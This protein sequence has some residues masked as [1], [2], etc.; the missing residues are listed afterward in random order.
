MLLHKHYEFA[1][2]IV[3]NMDTVKQLE[4]HSTSNK[5]TFAYYFTE[6][7]KTVTMNPLWCMPGWLKTKADHADELPFVFGVGTIVKELGNKKDSVWKGIYA[8]CSIRK[9]TWV[10]KAFF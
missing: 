1:G 9:S 5:A 2:E 3:F 8:I 4:Q 6:F 10:T 7:Y